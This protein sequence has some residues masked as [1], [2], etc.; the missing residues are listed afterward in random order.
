MSGFRRSTKI[1]L[2]DLLGT[3]LSRFR[4]IKLSVKPVFGRPLPAS[5]AGCIA[6]MELIADD[7]RLTLLRNT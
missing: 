6:I 3:D 1:Y 2:R 5:T 7:L 4:P